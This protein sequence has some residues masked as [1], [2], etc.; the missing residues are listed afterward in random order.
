MRTFHHVGLFVNDLVFGLEQ[1]KKTLEITSVSEV[2]A[3]ENLLVHV[4]FAID[5]SGVRYELV[6]PFGSGNPVEQVL[7]SKKNILNH[8]AYLSDCFESDILELRQSGAIPLGAPKH[9]K[10]FEGR[11]V[12]FFLTTLGFIFELIEGVRNVG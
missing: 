7:K 10:A 3:D 1:L 9:A 6:A 5:N 4:Q 11:R 2:I 8:V 12:V